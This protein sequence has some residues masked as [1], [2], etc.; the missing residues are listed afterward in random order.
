M[1]GSIQ[2]KSQLWWQLLSKFPCCHR[3]LRVT[4]YQETQKYKCRNSSP[5]SSA[6]P[7]KNS[8]TTCPPLPLP[9][10]T[11]TPCT[12][13]MPKRKHKMEKS[14]VRWQSD[15]YTPR[16][17][18]LRLEIKGKNHCNGKSQSEELMQWSQNGKCPSFSC[19]MVAS[20][21]QP[22]RWKELIDPN[23]D[24]NG[25]H[26]RHVMSPFPPR[27]IRSH[28]GCWGNGNVVMTL[29]RAAKSHEKQIG[30][31]KKGIDYKQRCR[32]GVLGF[33]QGSQ[34]DICAH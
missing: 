28:Q 26:Q 12:A 27:A 22:S 1:Q 11:H 10:P 2:G 14:M 4:Q 16:G 31:G 8:Q 17:C 30:R 20:K 7:N 6:V 23:T 19:V 24:L 25:A 33:L 15:T 29:P 18:S 9:S 34:C 21:G 5:D 13:S 3:R 32:A